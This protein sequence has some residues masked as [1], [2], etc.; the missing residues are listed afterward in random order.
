MNLNTI[1]LAAVRSF[2]RKNT[3]HNMKRQS[4]D[5]EC[6]EKD[7]SVTDRMYTSRIQ[8]RRLRW[9]GHVQ[10]M[11]NGSRARQALHWIPTGYR[12]TGRPKIIW[13]DVIMKD[14]SQLNAT[15]DGIC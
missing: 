6:Q 4:K 1:S 14:I 3:E 8:G 7:R 11:E 2:T 5:R 15:W 9:F 12:K 13:R 10:R